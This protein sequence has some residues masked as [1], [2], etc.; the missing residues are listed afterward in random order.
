VVKSV[1]G[2]LMGKGE[3]Y[4]PDI[5]HTIPSHSKAHWRNSVSFEVICSFPCPPVLFKGIRRT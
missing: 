5:K 1:E 2:K 4:K 3:I